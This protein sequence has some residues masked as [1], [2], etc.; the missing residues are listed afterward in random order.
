[1]KGEKGKTIGVTFQLWGWQTRLQFEYAYLQRYYRWICGRC[2]R[3]D[4]YC[5]YCELV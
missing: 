5:D 1:M 2:K 3:Y 4:Q